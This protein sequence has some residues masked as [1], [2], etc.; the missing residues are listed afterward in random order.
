MCGLYS[1]VKEEIIGY[2]DS[3]KYRN[4]VK[5]LA[6]TFKESGT[7]NIKEF[8]DLL[9]DLLK[10]DP[11]SFL[12]K[13]YVSFQFLTRKGTSSDDLLKLDKY[14]IKNYGLL[15][16]EKLLRSFLGTIMD[17]HGSTTGRIFLTPYRIIVCGWKAA[18]SATGKPGSKSLIGTVRLMKKE[19]THIAIG[20]AIQK[21]LKREVSELDLLQYGYSYPISNT[22]KVKKKKTS[23]NYR[24]DVEYERKGKEKVETLN[25]SIV[26]GKSEPREEIVDEIE[27]ALS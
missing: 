22:S 6:N 4:P 27:S 24:V 14:I 5:I 18:K 2:L 1:N 23:I 12:D 15:E 21:A 7:S 8:G 20:R 3:G 25:I 19:Y 10:R 17:K 11:E 16:G 26:P 9:V 13:I